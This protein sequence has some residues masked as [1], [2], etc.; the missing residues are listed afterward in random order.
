MT[1]LSSLSIDNFSPKARNAIRRAHEFAA[2]QH[3]AGVSSSHLFL[4][5]L[6]ES[7]PES[8][9]SHL[10]ILSGVSQEEARMYAQSALESLPMQGKK[11]ALTRSSRRILDFAAKEALRQNHSTVKIEH[12]FIGC[13]RYQ[14]GPH[15]G[16]VLRPLGLDAAKLRDHLRGMAQSETPYQAGSPL[17]RLTEKSKMVIESAHEEMRASYCGRISK[18]HLLLGLLAEGESEVV[19]IIQS[20]GIDLEKLR[21]GV[22]TQILSDGHIASPQKKF[23][24]AS[25]RAL[26]RAK[27][28]ADKQEHA[29]IG[30]QHLMVALMPHSASPW[31]KWSYGS[32]MDDPLENT[33]KDLPIELIKTEFQR[34]WPSEKLPPRP[35]LPKPRSWVK[36]DWRWMLVG[37]ATSAIFMFSHLALDLFA[38]SFGLSLLVASLG[39]L[40]R[41]YPLR[42]ITT[43]LFLGLLVGGPGIQGAPV[44]IQLKGK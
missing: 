44:W 35:V 19:L 10:L 33:W 17:N 31:E 12:L 40:T 13:I 4:G 3:C 22:R 36:V 21:Q 5:V 25:K 29:F 18:A 41:N 20:M 2:E 8:T 32:E 14:R 39:E 16:E 43:S 34:R 38:S 15:V 1:E 6:S 7:E 27:K 28:E 26:E 30:P 37:S 11:P 42:D 24:P 9:V 23:T